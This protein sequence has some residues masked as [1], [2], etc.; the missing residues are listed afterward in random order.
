MLYLVIKV[1]YLYEYM[2]YRVYIGR[3]PIEDVFQYTHQESTI[4]D[5]PNTLI[6]NHSGSGRVE[7]DMW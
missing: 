5:Y 6:N 7:W 4:G 1:K 2:A 3:N